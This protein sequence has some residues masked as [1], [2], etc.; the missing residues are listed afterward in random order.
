MFIKWCLLKNWLFSEVK[1]K[2]LSTP[3]SNLAAI[4]TTGWF[5]WKKSREKYIHT[6]T[7]NIKIAKLFQGDLSQ[8]V[9]DIGRLK[10]E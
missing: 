8:S 9:H 3:T 2:M 5:S 6:T 4:S 1:L 7:K 10:T